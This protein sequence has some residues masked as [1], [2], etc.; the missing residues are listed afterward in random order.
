VEENRRSLHLNKNVAPRNL[1]ISL[2]NKYPFKIT[3]ID[4]D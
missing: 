4:A 2:G 1:D 3:S